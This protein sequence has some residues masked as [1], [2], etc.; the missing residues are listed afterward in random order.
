MK[1][2]LLAVLFC[3]CP[4]TA[5]A[6]DAAPENDRLP[7]HSALSTIAA[8][9]VPR[10]MG[11]WFE[12]AKFPNWFQKKCTGGTKAEY[13][14]KNDGMVQVINRCRAEGGETIEAIGAARQIGPATSPKLEVRFAPEWLSFLPFVW[15]DYWVIDLDERYQLVAVS[16]P[17]KEY[18]WI[19][20]RTPNIDPNDYKNLL[21]RLRQ[22]GFDLRKLE[23][24]KQD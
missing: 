20:A 2:T 8:L 4:L 16:E 5:V 6:G 23:V 9:D 21:A 11:T 1:T 17:K 13:S 22:K 24:T 7:A 12:I 15:G 3:L 14:L 18:L 19:L 10:Y